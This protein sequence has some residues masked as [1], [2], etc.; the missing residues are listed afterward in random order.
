MMDGLQKNNVGYSISCET[1]TGIVVG[2][3]SRYLVEEYWWDDNERFFKRLCF[4]L[5]RDTLI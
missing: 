3:A 1:S 2:M 4:R 5:V